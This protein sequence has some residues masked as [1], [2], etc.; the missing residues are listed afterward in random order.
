[1][2]TIL[3]L[4]ENKDFQSKKLTPT[5]S[6]N[7][8]VT[9][10]D[11]STIKE[12]YSNKD[13]YIFGTN[14]SDVKTKKPSKNDTFNTVS[15]F[16]EQEL[17]GLR[18]RSAAE[19]PNPVLYGNEVIR[20]TSRTTPLLDD[21]KGDVGGG[22]LIGGALSK[23]TGGAVKSVSGIATA[24]NKALG[25]PITYIPTRLVGKIEGEPPTDPKAALKALASGNLGPHSQEPITKKLVGANGTE[26]GKLLKQSG[27]GNPKTIVKNVAGAA[28]SEVKNKVRGA[29]FGDN[30]DIGPNKVGKNKGAASTDDNPY[31]KQLKDRPSYTSEGEKD[32]FKFAIGKTSNGIDLRKVS[33]I[34]GVRRAGVSIPGPLGKLAQA[35]NVDLPPEGRFGKTEYALD[36]GTGKAVQKYSPIEGQTYSEIQN[37]EN[38]NSSLI[39]KRGMFPNRDGINMGD[40]YET[41]IPT[42]DFQN[43]DDPQ[44]KVP[45]YKVKV[46]GNEYQ[47]LIPLYIGRWNNYPEKGST[48]YPL[49]AFRCTINGLNETVSP[50]WSSNSFIGNPYKYYIYESVER[51]VSFNLQL[52][53]MNPKELANNWTKIT[54]LTKLAYPLVDSMMAHPN[55]LTFS[56]GDMYRGKIG[57]LESLTYSFPDNGTWETDIEGLLLPKF[58]DAS[59]T[60]KFV[61]NI[62]AGSITGLY[63]FPKSNITLTDREGKPKEASDT[64]SQHSI[65]T[66]SS[67]YDVSYS[68]KDVL[69]DEAYLYDRHSFTSLKEQ[70]IKDE[71]NNLVRVNVKNK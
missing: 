5:Q 24:F 63:D 15:N 68:K 10:A 41:E 16:A 3:D 2:P 51:S 4:F 56:L 37:E 42:I 36:L 30:N 67:K 28:I 61:E 57:I 8:E 64:V 22:G 23:L 11:T 60:I 27:G 71:N 13:S 25:I 58:I 66:D 9:S 46:D 21:M 52:F 49:M 47:D 53:C 12:M 39:A 33:P 45:G 6:P 70:N 35:A 1:M 54:N 69:K 59:L 62:E 43:G 14:Y 48:L 34:Y 38:K 18:I 31:S 29:L 20:I 44:R 32:D 7:V 19:L 65:Y 50:S 55:F 17:N 40:I 26:L